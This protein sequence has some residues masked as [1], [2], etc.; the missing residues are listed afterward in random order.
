MIKNKLSVF[1]RCPY[2]NYEATY[3]QV[4][5]G[6]TSC[7]LELCCLDCGRKLLYIDSELIEITS[8]TVKESNNER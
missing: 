3:K 2:C 6:Q 4:W 7:S 8:I 1:L 5:V